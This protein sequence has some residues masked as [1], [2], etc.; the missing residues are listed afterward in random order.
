MHDHT[1]D[2]IRGYVIQDLA[3]ATPTDVE[4]WVELYLGLDYATLDRWSKKISRERWFEDSAVQEALQRYCRA[5]TEHAR[6]QP[7]IDLFNRVKE[8]AHRTLNLHGPG[9]TFP[10]ADIGLFRCAGRPV[11]PIREHGA[12]GAERKPDIILMRQAAM[13]PE[14]SETQVRWPDV[15]SWFALKYDIFLLAE[16]NR[17]RVARGLPALTVDQGNTGAVDDLEDTQIGRAHV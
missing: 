5:K 2:S 9:N 6:Y 13:P 8:K 1:L 11:Q 10:I 3:D 17:A 15:L 4:D 7:F 12:L 14:N 16:L